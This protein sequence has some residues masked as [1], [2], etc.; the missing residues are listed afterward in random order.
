MAAAVVALEGLAVAAV[1]VV[2]VAQVQGVEEPGGLQQPYLQ[3]KEMMAVPLMQRMVP[4]ILV[5]AVAVMA[6]VAV[7]AILLIIAMVAL[8]GLEPIYPYPV[9]V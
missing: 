7:R 9:R 5:A 4:L 3:S 6:R 8:A 1:P 2:V